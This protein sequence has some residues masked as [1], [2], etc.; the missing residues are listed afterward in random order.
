M[1]ILPNPNGLLNRRS[2]RS[3]TLPLMRIRICK[4]A[5]AELPE[6]RSVQSS[7]TRSW[8]HKGEG[9]GAGGAEEAEEE[10]QG[11]DGKIRR[12]AAEDDAGDAKKNPGKQEDAPTDDDLDLQKRLKP[13]RVQ[14]EPGRRV[15]K[16]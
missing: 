14:P 7:P 5:R 9:A 16:R 12:Q 4:T 6:E 10:H 8:H 15:T 13:L 3:V 2:R 1:N 11:E